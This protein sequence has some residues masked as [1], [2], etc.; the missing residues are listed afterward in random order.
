MMISTTDENIIVTTKC[1]NAC[2]NLHASQYYKVLLLEYLPEIQRQIYFCQ[3]C[4][5]QRCLPL[6]PPPLQKKKI[7]NVNKTIQKKH[8][9]TNCFVEIVEYLLFIMFRQIAMC[10][11]EG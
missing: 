8:L 3:R 11:W 9:K 10:N 6:P 4:Q 7:K 5:S 2:Y 1:Q